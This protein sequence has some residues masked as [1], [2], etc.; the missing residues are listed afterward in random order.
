MD[1]LMAENGPGSSPRGRGKLGVVLR[2]AALP[3]LIPAWAGNTKKSTSCAAFSQAHPRVGGE[4]FIV[5]REM[6]SR[7]GSSPRGRGKRRGCRINTGTPRLIPAW[8][9]K[10]LRGNWLQ[11]RQKAHPRVG[12]ENCLTTVYRLVTD[13]SSPRGRGKPIFFVCYTLQ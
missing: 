11:Q 10:T 13:G 6:C 5:C 12:G 7:R 2:Q 3:G 8:A 1:R 9:G 4:N